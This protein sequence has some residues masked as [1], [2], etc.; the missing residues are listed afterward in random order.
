MPSL[1]TLYKEHEVSGTQ[2]KRLSFLPLC[3]RALSS[4]ASNPLG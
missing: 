1:A 3:L 2:R 4:M